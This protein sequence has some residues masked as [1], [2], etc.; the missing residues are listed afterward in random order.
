M[1]KRDTLLNL[2]STSK[3]PE[4]IPAAFF[5]HFDSA[6][7]KGQAAIDK[8]LEYFRYTG[9]DIVNCTRAPRAR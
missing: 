4:Y 3:Q 7:H 1:T 2:I 8:H 9:M 6:F 5:I